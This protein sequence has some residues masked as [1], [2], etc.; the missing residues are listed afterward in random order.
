VVETI[1]FAWRILTFDPSQPIAAQPEA[2]TTGGQLVEMSVPYVP[3]EKLV[4]PFLGKL[5][6]ETI[7][8]ATNNFLRS[9]ENGGTKL[10]SSEMN[11][12]FPNSLTYGNAEETFI[13][14]TVEVDKMLAEGI[15]R[16][17]I[18]TRLGITDPSF[19]KGDL[20]RVDV[21]PNMLKELNLRSPTGSEIGANSSFVQGGKT[22]G[23]VTEAIVNGIP[24]K[25]TG[26]TTTI[27]Q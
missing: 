22:S 14:P 18:A 11:A 7:T 3:Y 17:E 25:A 13:A 15:G 1:H 20:L 5:L 16:K 4:G 27:V 19:L 26:V 2:K 8:T 6:P 9:F 24:K 23:G 21:S 10:M 12:K